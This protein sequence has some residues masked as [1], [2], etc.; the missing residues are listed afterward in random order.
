MRPSL[1]LILFVT[2]YLFSTAQLEDTLRIGRAETPERILAPLI[3]LASDALR[4][5]H[6]GTPE[7]DTAAA[8]IAK[9]FKQAGARPVPGVGGYF[10]PFSYQF[11]AYS[12]VFR[13]R[14]QAA[15]GLSVIRP[16]RM[17]NVL[18]YVEGTDPVLRNQYIVLSSHYDHLGV[19]DSVIVENGKRDS[20]FNGARDNATGTAAVIAA[21]RFFARY[22]AKRSIV[23]ICYSGE[24]EDL[25]GSDYYANHPL[26]PLDHTVYNLN[27]DNASYNTTYA[28]CL[29]GLTRTSEDPL[30][31]KACEAY[32][33]AVLDDP[34]GELFSRSDNFSLASKGVPAPTYS[35]GMT[36]WD[37]TVTNRYHRLSDE[38]GNMDLGYAVKF[39]RAYILMAQYIANDAVQPRWTPGDPYEAAWLTLF[40]QQPR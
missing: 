14:L 13:F 21:A 31:Y 8:Y 22:P 30:I 38:T 28:I 10:Q 1:L 39:I 12:P 2:S 7:I 37:A 9:Q 36:D 27:V 24:E 6:V 16:I 3:Y 15:E 11:H 25:I 26:V 33:F 35:M 40:R 29:F 19:T 18:A 34:V 32:G 20:I 4:G 23:F 5:R 17:T